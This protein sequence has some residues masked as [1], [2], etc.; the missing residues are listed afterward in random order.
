MPSTGIVET[1]VR[2][3]GIG[4]RDRRLRRRPEEPHG[5]RRGHVARVLEQVEEREVAGRRSLGQVPGR[6][7]RLD[8]RFRVGAVAG[9]VPPHRA[10]DHHRTSPIRSASR[11]APSVS[12]SDQRGIHG[13]AAAA[14]PPAAATSRSP[15]PSGWMRSSD[16]AR[17][18]RRRRTA[19][20][21]C[22]RRRCRRLRPGSGGRCRAGACRRPARRG[23]MTPSPSGS[24]AG[25]PGSAR[26][27]GRA[28][29]TFAQ[30]VVEAVAVGSTSPAWRHGGRRRADRDR[31]RALGGVAR[32]SAATRKRDGAAAG[33][34]LADDRV[35]PRRSSAPRSS[36]QVGSDVVT[37]TL[38]VAADTPELKTDD[39]GANRERAGRHG[40]R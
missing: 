3:D 26:D 37:L 19:P 18:C 14:C 33:T 25:P 12:D 24:P 1:R 9:R 8:G 13:P 35:E 40:D 7:R 32:G 23:S 31:R 34:G 20:A 4:L 11:T 28:G 30:L 2:R 6:R 15:P 36:A 22:R 29:R 21:R 17:S 27:S 5:R 39:G 38:S 10:I 16:A